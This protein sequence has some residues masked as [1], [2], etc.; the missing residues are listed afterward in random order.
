MKSEQMLKNY[1][2]LSNYFPKQKDFVNNGIY[3]NNNRHDYNLK[4]IYVSMENISD[5][6]M[7]FIDDVSKIDFFYKLCDK[8]EI[9]RSEYTKLIQRS[10]TNIKE[11]GSVL[12]DVQFCFNEKNNTQN[13]IFL[14]RPHIDSKDKLI[15]ILLYFPEQPICETEDSGEL[16]LYET[17]EPF[18]ETYMDPKFIRKN[19][20]KVDEVSYLHNHGLIFRNSEYAVH[21]P[22]TLINQE[23][24][25]RRFVN[26]IFIKNC[27]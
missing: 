4:N 22:K 27:E 6:W 3:S 2:E 14:R 20:R 23:K 26:I 1:S 9:D 16:I 18:R 7:N 5:V 8:L 10:D 24:Y 15:V 13:A 12:I 17:K 11:N 25:N 19:L 21:A